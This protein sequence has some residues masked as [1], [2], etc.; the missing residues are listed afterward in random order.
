[1][2]APDVGG[3]FGSKL[4]VYAEEQL[5]LALARKLGRPVKWTE[6][7]SEAYLATIHGR[8]VIQ[9]IELAAKADGTMTAVRARLTAAMGA[10][11][12]LVTPAYRCSAPGCT[13]ARTTSRRM[14]STCTGVFTNT[15]PTDAIAAPA[16]PS[17]RTRSS[18]PWTRWRASSTWTRSS[19]A[20]RTSS[21]SFPTQWH[22]D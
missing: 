10:Y 1:M 20:A 3:G 8:D 4:N 2:I 17:P 19:C 21:P 22:R 13:A 11:L 15:T 5:A 16:G 12:Q 9:E 14:S 18:E 7:R 6:E